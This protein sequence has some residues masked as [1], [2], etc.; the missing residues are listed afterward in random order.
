MS[1]TSLRRFKQGTILRYGFEIYN[2]KLDGAQKPNLTVKV[3]IFRDGKMILDGKTVPI[4]LSQQT[5]L[6]RI[7]SVGAISLGTAMQSGDYV[8]QIVV[9]DNLAKGKRQIATQFVQFEIQ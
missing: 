8:L 9:T 2:A 6:Q 7:K 5:D 3:R 1:D 4:D